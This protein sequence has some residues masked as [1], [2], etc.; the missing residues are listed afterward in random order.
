MNIDVKHIHSLT[1]FKRNASQLVDEARQTR[2]PLVLTVNGRAEAVVLGAEVYQ[3][4]VEQ[5]EHARTVEAV[6]RMD[7]GEGRPAGKALAEI[8]K[9]YVGTRGSKVRR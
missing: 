2:R 6:K 3:D 9:R 8:R 5:L 4:M 1:D 7:Q